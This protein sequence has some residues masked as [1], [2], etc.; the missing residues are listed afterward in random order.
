MHAVSFQS[1]ELPHDIIQSFKSR[2]LEWRR[3]FIRIHPEG[4]SPYYDWRVTGMPRIPNASKLVSFMYKSKD[5]ALNDR[6]SGATCFIVSIPYEHRGSHVPDDVSHLYVVTSGHV[7]DKFDGATHIGSTYIR[8]NAVPGSLPIIRHLPIENWKTDGANDIA[9]C[10]IEL[11]GDECDVSVVS[12]EVF[13]TDRVMEKADVG[14]GDDVFMIGRFVD[15]P[16]ISVNEPVARFGSISHIVKQNDGD[17]NKLFYL[18]MHS[19]TGYSGSPVFVYRTIGSNLKDLYE[20]RK[21][22]VM[23]FLLLLGVHKGSFLEEWEIHRN[24][25]QT[26]KPQNWKR[27]EDL[28]TKGASGISMVVPAQHLYDLLMN[29]NDLKSMRERRE[30]E[31]ESSRSGDGFPIQYENL[32]EKPE[33]ITGDDILRNMLNTPPETHE[34]LKKK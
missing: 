34:K 26:G 23:H 3:N 27:D 33:Q 10:P 30:L 1:P 8:I 21:S 17:K 20:D 5:D 14:T 6:I 15:H 31:E 12:S 24:T 19:R 22:N 16:S 4:G 11:K 13:G 28:K 7:V 29:D 32:E 2:S 25:A 9:V 18:D